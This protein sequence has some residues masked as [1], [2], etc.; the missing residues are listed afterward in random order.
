MFGFINRLMGSEENVQNPD[1]SDY[2]SMVRGSNFNQ[3]ISE[4]DPQAGFMAP[5]S[6]YRP[7]SMPS[8]GSRSGPLGLPNVFGGGQRPSSSVGSG[9]FV[10]QAKPQASR[11]GYVGS[12]P[13]DMSRGLA[14][15]QSSSVPDIDLSGLTEEEKAKI[16]SVMLRAQEIE[17][18]DA[19][20]QS[21]VNSEHKTSK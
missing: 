8:S 14:P 7:S 6:G 19:L 15:I 9:G 10:S 3:A 18:N 21:D 1:V 11:F 2:S 13:L 20:G 12:S 16:Q 17:R 4:H 5:N